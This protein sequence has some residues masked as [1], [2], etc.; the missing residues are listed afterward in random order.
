MGQQKNIFNEPII[1]NKKQA[2]S[3][4]QVKA[5]KGDAVI[6]SILWG[7]V[8]IGGIIATAISYDAAAS[9]RSGNQTYVIFWG[10]ILFGL[11]KSIYW[12]C[13]F[14]DPGIRLKKK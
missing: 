4:K 10:A 14:F 6:R 9:A 11:L 13:V 1:T 12:I 2:L 3:A 8:C 7:L 5:I